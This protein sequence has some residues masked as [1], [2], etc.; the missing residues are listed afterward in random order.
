MLLHKGFLIMSCLERDLNLEKESG[1]VRLAVSKIIEESI[2]K[3]QGDIFDEEGNIEHLIQSI[4]SDGICWFVFL[5]VPIV[6]STEEERKRQQTDVSLLVF[7]ISNKD[8]SVSW[9]GI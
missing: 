2:D 7:C 6:I 8:T 5:L 1:K 3:M 9:V 4:F